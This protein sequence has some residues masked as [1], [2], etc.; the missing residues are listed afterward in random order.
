[1]KTKI[2][3]K[4]AVKKTVKKAAVKK[5]FS[6]NPDL[7][8]LERGAEFAY[9]QSQAYSIDEIVAIYRKS[10]ISIAVPT[11][12]NALRISN[13]PSFVR[14]AIDKGEVKASEVLDLLKPLR[15]GD[16]KKMPETY[17]EFEARVKEGLDALIAE[18]QERREM[19]EKA[20][21]SNEDGGLKLTKIRTVKM[22]GKSLSKIRKSDVL[23][24]P[25]AAVIL[26]FIKALEDGQSHEEILK[27]IKKKS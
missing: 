7:N 13:A 14:Q 12:Y 25:R 16:N 10:G 11:V 22:I 4:T 20:G 17:K 21:F 5:Q 2:T 1:M 3:K 24:N 8:K 19:L 9:L 27:L 6:P 23:K 26:E 18:R 15:D